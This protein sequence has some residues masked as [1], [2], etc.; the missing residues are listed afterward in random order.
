MK[1]LILLLALATAPAFAV[2]AP[3]HQSVREIKAIISSPELR[4][5]L[6]SAYGINEIKK[7]EEGYLVITDVHCLKVNVVT[8]LPMRIGPKQFHLEFEGLIEN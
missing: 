7:V 4:E 2:L 6:P 1:R 8:D 3:I 5:Y